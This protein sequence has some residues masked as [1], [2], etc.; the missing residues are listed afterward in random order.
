MKKRIA[1]VGLNNFNNIGDRIIAE[2]TNYLIQLK[3]ENK[4]E[5]YFVDVSP[6][7][8]YCR[9]HLPFRFKCFNLIRKLEHFLTSVWPSEKLLYYIQYFSWKIKLYRYY[10][11]QLK[12]ADAVVFSGG[13]FIKYR[14]QELNYLVDM[15]T[16]L[17]QEKGIPV[18]MNAMGI[19][20]YSSTDLRCQKLKNAINRPCVKVITARDNLSLLNERYIANKLIITELVGDPAFYTP[21]CY[22]INRKDSNIIGL[23]VIRNDIFVKYGINYTEDEVMNLYQE[24]I[25]EL[26]KRKIKWKLFSNG[27][28]SD[29]N[30]GMR[31]LESLG[32]NSSKYVPCPQNSKDF[33]DTMSG[34]E[35]IIGARLHACITAYSLD[36]P[37]IGLVWNEKL[38]LFG[39]LIGKKEN[40][41]NVEQL[42]AK[43]I[44][45]ILE[46]KRND[47]YDVEQRNNLKQLTV[48]YIDNFIKML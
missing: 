15:I 9:V 17:S 29:Y 45:D 4:V 41:I 46:K 28:T 42:N 23:G 30:F 13:G 24:I 40:F 22:Q 8:S 26:E 31:L 18:M 5:S 27:L 33:A 37:A 10:D 2:T 43:Y 39:E 7:D 36:I 16:K 25:K 47:C 44:V 6:Y 32:I 35:A 34:F 21:E 12:T 19:E 14:A 11:Q 20:G 48:E 1:L 38:K 3:G